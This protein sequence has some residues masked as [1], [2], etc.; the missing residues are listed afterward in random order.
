MAPLALIQSGGFAGRT[1][2]EDAPWIE[3]PWRHRDAVA[4]AHLETDIARVHAHTEAEKAICQG[5]WPFV[6]PYCS[7]RFQTADESGSFPY[8]GPECSASAEAES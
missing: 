8:C 7:T 2:F 4:E 3:Q 1:T 5:D 6:C